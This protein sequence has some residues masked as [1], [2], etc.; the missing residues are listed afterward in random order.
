MHSIHEYK[1]ISVSVR[2]FTRFSFCFILAILGI[3]FYA[4]ICIIWKYFCFSMTSFNYT[5]VAFVMKYFAFSIHAFANYVL[6]CKIENGRCW[7]S[8]LTLRKFVSSIMSTNI[9][10]IDNIKQQR[11][12]NNNIKKRKRTKNEKTRNSQ[13]KQNAVDNARH[14]IVINKETHKQN[15]FYNLFQCSYHSRCRIRN[16]GNSII[17]SVTRNY[18][19]LYHFILSFFL[20]RD[21]VYGILFSARCQHMK[22]RLFFSRSCCSLLK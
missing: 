6:V 22:F 8:L 21:Y 19:F 20:K 3:H 15:K 18:I 7:G 12:T 14:G 11:H 2:V 13:M 16:N 1:P 9:E 5:I 17:D 4:R 10:A